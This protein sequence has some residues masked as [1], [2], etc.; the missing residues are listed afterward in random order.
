MNDALIKKRGFF[1]LVHFEKNEV[2]KWWNWE[3]KKSQVFF[4]CQGF[5]MRSNEE[6]L[7]EGT[8]LN[9]NRITQKRINFD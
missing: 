6:S 5:N 1:Y 7:R 8:K 9:T 3:Q 4:S 2:E